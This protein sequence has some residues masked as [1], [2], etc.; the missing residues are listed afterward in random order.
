[1]Q[2]HHL[3]LGTPLYP[4]FPQAMQCAL[5]GMGCFWGAEKLL[6]SIEGVYTTMV[7]YAGGQHPH[8]DY[9]TVCSG[10]TGH[11]EVVR[12][13]YNPQVLAYQSLLKSF[14]TSHNPCQGM[15]QGNDIGTQ[16]RSA[17]YYCTAEQAELAIISRQRYQ[18]ALSAAAVT[19]NITTEIASAPTFYY[20]EDYHQQYL[21]AHPHGYCG[22]AGTGVA[23][24]AGA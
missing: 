10:Q 20:A 21:A 4:P 1:M 6:W 11:C 14:W 16:Y 19:A 3:V 9:Y 8:P 12:V 7:G 24:P 22:L 23:Y 18:R 17:I 13:I 2:R 15:R 5:F